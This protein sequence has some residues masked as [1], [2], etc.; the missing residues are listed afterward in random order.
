MERGRALFGALVLL[1]VSLAA[2]P[3]GAAP[4][5]VDVD[6]VVYPTGEHPADS[7]AVQA[8]VD[9]GG[10][11][12]LES[13][14]VDGNP[15]PFDLGP[16]ET[17]AAVVLTDDVVILG[18]SGRHPT[19]IVG[20]LIPFFGTRATHTRIEGITFE[21]AGVSAAIFIRST[22]AE[23][24]D[25]RV[26]GVVGI[27]LTFPFVATEGR[28]IKFL[29]NSDPAGAITGD[30]LI[31]G[32]R[33]DDMHADLSEAIVFDRVA[34]DVTIVDNHVEDV[35]SGGVLWL[36]SSGDLEVTR[37]TIVPGPGTGSDFQSGNGVQALGGGPSYRFT[38]N[39]IR[40]ENPNA[41]GILLA[42][43]IEFGWGAVE[44]PVVTGNTITT[45]SADFGGIT[46]YGDVNNGYVANNRL[47]GTALYGLGVLPLFTDAETATRNRFVGNNVTGLD[48]GLAHTLVFPHA[49]DTA[50]VGNAGTVL[51]LGTDTVITGERPVKGDLSGVPG[52]EDAIHA[53]AMAGG[54]HAG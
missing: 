10:T 32:N 33:F 43:Q 50:V 8:A 25:N 17:G 42:G 4:P 47:R 15:T 46:L 52:R 24:V 40:C 37:N 7:A 3:A 20:G 12:L 35:A 27:E 19:R 5:K 51:D 29:G 31:A 26:T 21:G 38:Q 13:V 48:A 11:V 28:G 45:A 30:I 41:D 14:D 34:A 18:S 1:T 39:V 6:A 2:I 23:F 9:G 16:P 44:S 54:G 49:F 53:T 22:G 36:F